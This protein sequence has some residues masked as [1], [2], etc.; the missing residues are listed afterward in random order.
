MLE[1]LGWQEQEYFVV[2]AHREE[3]V[4]DPEQFAGL[5]EVLNGWPKTGRRVICLTHPR[6]RKRIEAEGITLA[7]TVSSC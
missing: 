4:D 5:I 3:N 2:S 7:A 6:T 1:R